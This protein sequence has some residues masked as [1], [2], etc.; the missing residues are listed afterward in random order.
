MRRVWRNCNS[1]A[2]ARAQVLIRADFRTAQAR[3][4]G[5]TAFPTL[6]RLLLRGQRVSDAVAVAEFADGRRF[7]GFGER[8]SIGFELLGR[9]LRTACILSRSAFARRIP[10]RADV[11]ARSMAFRV[12]SSAMAQRRRRQVLRTKSGAVTSSTESAGATVV[13]R[14]TQKFS[15]SS[16]SSA[17]R[18]Y[19]TSGLPIRPILTKAK[20][21]RPILPARPPPSNM[22]RSKAGWRTPDG[23]PDP[24]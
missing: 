24:H 11:R 21:S 18:S 14:V 20:S 6:V 15:Y 13:Q 9:A 10:L 2:V 1:S 8:A 7:L 3:A 12:V 4:H 23:L 5:G 16:F 22:R 19:R 17:A